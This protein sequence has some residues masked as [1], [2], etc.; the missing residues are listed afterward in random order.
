MYQNNDKKI[1][2]VVNK[3]HEIFT[4]FNSVCHLTAGIANSV[5]ELPFHCYNNEESGF[6][7][8]ISH[9][10][11]V[12]LKG[13]NSNQLKSLIEKCHQEK[14]HYNFFTTTMISNSA[15]QQKADTLNTPLEQLDFVAVALYGERESLL[16][17]TKK[18]SV[19][20]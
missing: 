2:V 20:K 11:I 7:A 18:F 4:L 6:M 15:S 19:F 3:N 1:Y 16:P 14:V 9:Y 17:L 13:N 8:N 5:K 10:P 12:V